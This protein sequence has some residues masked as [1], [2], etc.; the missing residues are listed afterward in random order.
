MSKV[1]EGFLFSVCVACLIIFIVSIGGC[2]TTQPYNGDNVK[3][4]KCVRDGHQ[5][6]C[7][8]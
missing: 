5:L 6:R 8:E 4:Q 7:E 1:I 3:V 2:N